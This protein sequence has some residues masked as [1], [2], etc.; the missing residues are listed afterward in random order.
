MPQ[1]T[2]TPLPQPT[3]AAPP[4]PNRILTQPATITACRADYEAAAHIRATLAAQE[5]RRR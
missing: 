2:S 4:Q 3:P 1:S 5:T